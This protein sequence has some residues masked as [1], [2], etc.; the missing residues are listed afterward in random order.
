MHYKYYSTEDFIQD[1]F[2][3]QWVFSPNEAINDYWEA[4]MVHYPIQQQK[5]EEA[6]EFLLAMNFERTVLESVVQKI[7]HGFNAAIDQYESARIMKE[8]VETKAPGEP[9]RK[10]PVFKIFYPIAASVA[11]AVLLF[12]YLFIY[13]DKYLPAW[14]AFSYQNE[15]TGLGEQRHIT[16]EDGSRVWLNAD[17]ELRY[18]RNFEGEKTREVYLTGE[19]FFAVSENKEH[20]FIVH[21]SDLAIKVLGTSFN[22]RAYSADSVVETTLVFGKV[23]IASWS[24][25]SLQ[26]VTLQPNQQARFSKEAKTM[27]LEETVNPENYFA[28]KDGWMIFDNKPFSYIKE[29]MERW[30]NVTIIMEDE[31]SLSCTYS[32]KFKDKTLHQVLEIFRITEA[33]NYRIEGSQVFI[34]GKLCQ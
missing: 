10:F 1:E 23:S 30:Y 28:W 13:K 34:D 29:M 3:Q 18:P 6:R 31:K 4:F 12:G 33:I 22:V 21:T 9:T 17:S 27:A 16:L 20:P 25:D 19:A 26:V 15:K 24:R 5:M 32:A 14:Q 7:Q 11:L 8:K 2:F